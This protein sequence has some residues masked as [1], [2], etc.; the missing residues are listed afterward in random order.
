MTKANDIAARGAEDASEE[1]NF[2]QAADV[3]N[4]RLPVVRSIVNVN[5][6]P[7]SAPDRG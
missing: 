2:S 3:I 7:D 4:R 6:P 5:G 1:N